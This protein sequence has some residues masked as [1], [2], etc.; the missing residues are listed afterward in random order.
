[1]VKRLSKV[2]LLHRSAKRQHALTGPFNQ[3]QES[4][5]HPVEGGHPLAFGIKGGLG[6]AFGLNGN[7][8]FG[9]A[10]ERRFGRVS[11]YAVCRLGDAGAEQRHGAGHAAVIRAQEFLHGHQVLGQ[12]AGL[13]GADQVHRSQRLNGIQA[14]DQGVAARHPLTAHGQR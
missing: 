3:Q 10:I 12:G 11:G 4:S 13:V 5:I 7:P 9:V 14:F 1:M 6:Q 2:I 8:F